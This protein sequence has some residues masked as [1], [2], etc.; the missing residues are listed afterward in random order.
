MSG[1]PTCG[2]TSPRH[3]FAAVPRRRYD[4]VRMLTFGYAAAWLVVRFLYIDDVARLPSIRFEPVGILAPFDTPPARWIVLV[5][6]TATITACVLAAIGR[7]V[8]AAAPLGAAGVWFIATLTS[9]FGQVFHTEHLLVL[10]LG[11]LGVAALV[12]RPS[13]EPSGWPLNLMMAVVVVTYVDAGIAKLRWSGAEW[14]TG[15]VLRN[16]VAVDNLRKWQVDDLYSP[17]GGWLAGVSWVW[18]PIAVL[19]LAVELG[20]PVALLARRV[21]Y[22]WVGAAWLFHVGIFVLMAI[23]FPYQLFGVAYVAFLPV[24]AWE[25]RLRR[26]RVPEAAFA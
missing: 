4:L 19:T 26:R 25:A 18:L 11:V 16:W 24:E 1:E 17:I 3:W 7:F 8:R 2:L 6:W 21:R 14:V 10:H 23:S 5:V 13:S 9:S 20:A 15:D 12:E 22:A